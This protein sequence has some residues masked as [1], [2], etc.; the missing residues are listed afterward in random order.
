M[1]TALRASLGVPDFPTLGRFVATVVLCS[2]CKVAFA[3]EPVGQLRCVRPGPVQRCAKVTRAGQPV[4]SAASVLPVEAHDV[5]EP[6]GGQTAVLHFRRVSCVDRAFTNTEKVLP[7]AG[8]ESGWWNG[9]VTLADVSGTTTRGTDD[10]PWV[11]P[12]A[13][14]PPDATEWLPESPRRVFVPPVLALRGAEL[15]VRSEDSGFRLRRPLMAGWNALPAQVP[16]NQRLQ[17]SVQAE[18]MTVVSARGLRIVDSA[19]ARELTEAAATLAAHQ[20]WAG[21]LAALGWLAPNLNGP[22]TD[23]S[24]VA[25]HRVMTAA[26]AAGAPSSTQRQVAAE[27]L[28]PARMALGDGIEAAVEDA[29]GR[30]QR[31]SWRDMLAGR[32]T[33][34][35]WPSGA[36]LRFR[37]SGIDPSWS[38]GLSFA[39]G[40]QTEPLGNDAFTEAVPRSPARYVEAQSGWQLDGKPVSVCWTLGT[41]VRSPVVAA[42]RAAGAGQ[43]R[44]CIQVP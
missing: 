2:L 10:D 40:G 8:S 30:T 7:C 1:H 26:N 43:V 15:L 42:Q 33:T 4:P 34:R 24:D 44:A 36:T 20:G 21:E 22:L 35:G 3:G 32:A 38:V 13:V 39:R 9:R 31:F 29:D 28:G 41:A 27:I 16:A 25:L 18:G 19:R 14:W 23:L 17:W 6:V 11:N 5:V 37:L 12:R